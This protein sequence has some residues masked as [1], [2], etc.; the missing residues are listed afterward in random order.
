VAPTHYDVLGV[1]P[2]ATAEQLRAAYLERARE[3][4]PDRWIDASPAERLTAERR[5]KDVTEA[6]RVLGDTGRRRRYDGEIGTSD[7]RARALRID[8]ARF[9]TREDGT[10][11]EVVERPD[12]VARLIQALPWLVLVA[13]L[14]GIFIFTAY[15][16]T[17]SSSVSHCVDASGTRVA[18]GTPGAKAVVVE[19]E[20]S[21]P[22]PKGTESLVPADYPKKLCLEG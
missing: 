3:A 15:A 21:S 14:G 11:P 2:D 13:V 6:W 10:M 7:A 12:A 4:H 18:C 5:M 1:R 9:G 17:G 8:D 22:C 16:V 20:P 19:V